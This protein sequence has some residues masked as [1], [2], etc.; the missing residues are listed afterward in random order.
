MTLTLV[1]SASWGFAYGG[2]WLLKDILTSVI[3]YD[4][5]LTGE[6]REAQYAGPLARTHRDARTHRAV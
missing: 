3:D 6:R 5:F 4:E 2:Q 1:L